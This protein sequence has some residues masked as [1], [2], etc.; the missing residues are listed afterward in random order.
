M[1]PKC[2]TI[3]KKEE[4]SFNTYTHH[5]WWEDPHLKWNTIP[6]T[7]TVQNAGQSIPRYYKGTTKVYHRYTH[8]LECIILY[9]PG[10][11][12]ITHPTCSQI[13]NKLS[14][15]TSLNLDIRNKTKKIETHTPPYT[16][17]KTISN[18]SYT[19]INKD[20]NTPHTPDNCSVYFVFFVK[21]EKPIY[22]PRHSKESTQ[23]W[24]N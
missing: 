17:M 9:I 10:G 2:T 7:S 13:V 15:I 20:T 1:Y 5:V 24:W 11:V 22:K 3:D 16:K 23:D 6:T 4:T 18:H 19:T 8:I 14:P 21:K 12:H